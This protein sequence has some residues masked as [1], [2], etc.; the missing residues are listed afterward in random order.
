VVWAKRGKIWLWL[1]GLLD[2]S[3][4]RSVF[5]VD[6]VLGGRLGAKG[7]FISNKK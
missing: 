5:P 1:S 4:E 6:W 7:I 3:L 2:G